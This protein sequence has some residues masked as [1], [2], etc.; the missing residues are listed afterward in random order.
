M[1][2]FASAGLLGLAACLATPALAQT[3]IA[4]PTDGYIGVFGDIAATN[5]CITLPP[6]AATTL[7][8]IAVTGGQTSAGI[9]GAEFRVVDAMLTNQEDDNSRFHMLKRMIDQHLASLGS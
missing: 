4:Y 1:K 6:N 8:I 7:H 9:T 5:C 3:N 2:N